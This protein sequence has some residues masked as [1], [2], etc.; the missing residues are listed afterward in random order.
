MDP[1][2]FIDEILDWMFEFP[3]K[4]FSPTFEELGYESQFVF[5]N[6]GSQFIFLAA[7]P[8]ILVTSILLIYFLK[9]NEGG[10]VF[11]FASKVKANLV[12]QTL[13]QYT[14]INY[15]LLCVMAMINMY[16]EYSNPT[17]AFG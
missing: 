3:N 14:T 1:I 15:T 6:L 11:R 12:P 9:S 13:V 5:F 7:Q 10:R 2:L 8:I 17:K 4:A 16:M